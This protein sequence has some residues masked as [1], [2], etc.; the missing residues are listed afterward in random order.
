MTHFVG[1]YAFTDTTISAARKAWLSSWL[2]TARDSAGDEIGLHIHPY[3]CFI[4]V[5]QVSCKTDSAYRG[6]TDPTGYRIAL[7]RYTE[8]EAFRMFKCADSVFLAWGL[9]KP[10]AFRAG[11]WTAALHT[12]KALQRAAYN[13]DASGCNLSRGEELIGYPLGDWVAQNWPNVSDTSQP[14][15]P[16]LSTINSDEKPSLSILEAP[17]NGI[18]ADYI[19]SV[20]M[21]EVFHKIWPSGPLSRAKHLSI[22]YHPDSFNWYFSKLN[23][24]LTYI[25]GFLA[26]NDSGPVFY[27]RMSDLPHIWM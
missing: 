25:D 10:V 3:C 6:G 16:S 22:G 8:E 5:A 26:E 1:P 27:V 13:V 21:V 12:L 19:D 24:A 9:A 14:Y 7:D 15:Y 2:I 4:N 23:G 17:D 18:L 11:G 20:Q